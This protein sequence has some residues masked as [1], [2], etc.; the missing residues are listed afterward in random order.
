MIR[1]P[2]QI[3]CFLLLL[4]G[5]AACSTANSSIPANK[6]VKILLSTLPEQLLVGS[7]Q[8]VIDVVDVDGQP[9]QGADVEVSLG[10]SSMTMN[11]QDG[12]AAEQGKG[13]Y[14]RAVTLHAKGSYTLRIFVNRAGKTLKT[15]DFSLTVA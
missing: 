2:A 5:F 15:Q 4:I 9:L 6:D 1:K 10:M 12:Q 14:T 8:F 13:R 7:G 3:G 11:T